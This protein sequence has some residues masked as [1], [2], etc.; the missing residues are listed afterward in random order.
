LEPKH[1]AALN[2][3]GWIA[4]GQ[5]KT[6]QAIEY[7][8][9]A[10]EAAPTATAALSG[11]TQ[12]YMEQKKYDD[13]IKYYKMWLKVEPNNASAKKGLKEA[14]KAAKANPADKKKEETQAI[15]SATKEALRWLKNIDTG[16][17]GQSWEEMAEMA[18]SAVSKEQW[19]QAADPLKALGRFKSRKR[20]S[21]DY[22]TTLPG[23]PDG[24]YVI[25]KY[26]AVYEKKSKASETV[27]LVKEKDRQ[28]RVSG[29]FVN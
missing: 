4:K 2:G 7:W 26:Q 19:I 20:I 10:V 29:C 27:T 12:T 17:Y 8:T 5:K 25:L 3:L 14:Q 16:K 9:K 23:A 24:Q 1:A 13:A 15:K 28:W 22:T 11:L 6:K 21:A 18:K